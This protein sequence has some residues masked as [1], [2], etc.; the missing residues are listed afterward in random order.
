MMS[1]FLIKMFKQ[2]TLGFPHHHHSVMDSEPLLL[3]TIHFV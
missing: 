3:K 2:K 1:I